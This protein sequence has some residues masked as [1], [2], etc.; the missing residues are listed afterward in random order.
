MWCPPDF[1]MLKT[2][3]MWCPRISKS[4]NSLLPQML[5][6]NLEREWLGLCQ[7]RLFHQGWKEVICADSPPWPYAH[8]PH[9]WGIYAFKG[10]SS[11][12]SDELVR[13]VFLSN[14]GIAWSFCVWQVC[15]LHLSLPPSS[16]SFTCPCCGRPFVEEAL[17][18]FNC[19][20]VGVRLLSSQCL[21]L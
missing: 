10:P 20:I 14:P 3:A 7:E 17:R 19:K 18:Q 5:T 21:L 4:W 1:S 15:G 9:C 8:I 11:L 16:Y 12:R 2:A 6:L 13:F